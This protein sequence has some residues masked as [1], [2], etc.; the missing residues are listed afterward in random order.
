MSILSF[1]WDQEPAVVNAFYNPNTNDIGTLQISLSSTKRMQRSKFCCS[2]LRAYSQRAKVKT[3]I[4]FDVWNFWSLSLVFWYFCF[5]IRFRS[6]LMG[7]KTAWNKHSYKFYSISG[8][9][10]GIKL[11][12]SN[13]IAISV[14]RSDWHF[15]LK[16]PVR[17][18]IPFLKWQPF[19]VFQFFQQPSYSHSSTAN[20]FPSK[21]LIL[22][23]DFTI[24]DF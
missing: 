16:S 4:F 18:Y 2:T 8:W 6:V 3:K 13:L 22:W 5:R 11:Y 9:L 15:E 10:Q 12:L 20:F 21:E 17:K 19:F 7:L 14:N 24:F 1:R 23:S